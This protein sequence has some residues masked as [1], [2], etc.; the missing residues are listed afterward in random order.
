MQQARVV[1]VLDVL[2]VELPV[3]GQH[4]AVAA[5]HLHWRAHHPADARDDLGAEILFERRRVRRKRAEDE[6]RERREL[7][8]ARSVRLRAALRRHAAL[9]A[10]P[11]AEG[12]PGEVAA[13]V[14]APIVIDADDVARF[15]ALVEQE[16]RSA[17]RAAVLERVQVTVLVARHHHRHR[18]EARAAI[19]VG[20]CEL[21]FETEEIPG[22]PA[23]DAFLL[24]LVNGWVA[25]D[26][27]GHPREPFCRP[28]VLG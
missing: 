16:Q 26:P 3:A 23:K 6:A 20:V 18:T 15:A 24:L 5:E 11:L 1:G 4:L 22:R 17:V 9:A 2:H 28:A 27:I 7:E 12:D 8:L 13:Q 10:Q 19:A 14:V 25:I 21:R